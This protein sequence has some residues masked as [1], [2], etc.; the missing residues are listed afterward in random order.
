MNNIKTKLIMIVAHY[1]TKSWH[2]IMDI[3]FN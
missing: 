1:K 2:N 3:D